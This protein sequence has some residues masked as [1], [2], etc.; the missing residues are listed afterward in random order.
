M[1]EYELETKRRTEVNESDIRRIDE[2]EKWFTFEYPK[3]LQ[4]IA[5]YTYLGLKHNE[6]RYA[7]EIEAYDKE[8]ELRLL[9]GDEP[10]PPLK[11]KDLF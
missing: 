4:T 5:R 9:K 11:I 2:L 10:L 1:R 8:N 7:L 6:T 3:R